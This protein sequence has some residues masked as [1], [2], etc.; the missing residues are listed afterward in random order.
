MYTIMFAIEIVQAMLLQKE[1]GIFCT[2]RWN[3]QQDK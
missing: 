3:S 2:R 1:G